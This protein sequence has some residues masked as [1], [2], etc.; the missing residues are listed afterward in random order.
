MGLTTLFLDK[1]NRLDR[2]GQL[3]EEFEFDNDKIIVTTTK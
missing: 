2:D 1:L 3:E